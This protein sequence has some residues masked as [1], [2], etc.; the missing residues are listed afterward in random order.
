MPE[1]DISEEGIPLLEG[2]STGVTTMVE[3]LVEVDAGKRCL[4]L[5]LGHPQLPLV[6]ERACLWRLQL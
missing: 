5:A 1:P 3:V 4:T 2:G 6:A